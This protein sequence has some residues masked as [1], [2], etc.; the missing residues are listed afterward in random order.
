V[1]KNKKGKASLYLQAY[2]PSEE[3]AMLFSFGITLLKFSF[4]IFKPAR[5]FYN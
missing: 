4:L 1:R 5:S 3:S 2:L